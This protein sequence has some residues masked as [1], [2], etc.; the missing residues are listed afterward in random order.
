MSK[1]K[2]QGH[3]GSRKG[4]DGGRRQAPDPRRLEKTLN[5]IGKLLEEQHFES[6]D[7]ANAFLQQMLNSEQGLTA[8]EPQ[9]PL[10][11][12]QEYMY[13]AWRAE[14]TER[15]RLARRALRICKDCADAY[16][17]L[18]EETARSL[19]QA[20]DL[21]E[22]GVRAAERALGREMFRENAG[23]FWGILETRP[24]MRARAGLAITLW[25]LHE[26]QEAIEH[27]QDLLRLNPGDNQGLRYLLATC[28]LLE[29][30]HDELAQ[31]LRDYEG[32]GTAYWY[33]TKAL[34]S[35]R[36]HGDTVESDRLLWAAFKQNSL[37][38]DYLLGFELLPDQMPATIGFGDDSEA[39]D[40]AAA[41]GLAWEQT[42]GA[43]AWLEALWL[44]ELDLYD[45]PSLDFFDAAAEEM[46]S[47][48]IY[49][50]F[51]LQQWLADMTIPPSEHKTVQKALRAGV[52]AYAKEYMGRDYF[53]REPQSV[54][55][56]QLQDLFVFG[57]GAAQI[58]Q[59]DHVSRETKT[60]VAL[61]ALTAIQPA[62]TN[63]IPFGLLGLLG[64]LAQA[65]ALVPEAF[66]MSLIALEQHN[67][68]SFGS[69]EWMEGVTKEAMQSLAEWIV[70]TEALAEDEKLWAV[71]TL[72]VHTDYAS[73]L[74]KTLADRWFNTSHVSDDLKRD[75]CWGWIRGDSDVGTPPAMRQIMDAYLTGDREHMVQL[76][77]ENDFDPQEMPPLPEPTELP[78]GMESLLE[79]RRRFVFLPAYLKRLAIPGLVR[80][81]E[82]LEA[83]VDRFWDADSDYYVDA[84]NNGIAD[85]IG[86][87]SDRLSPQERRRLIERGINY[88]R[89]TTRKTFY[90]LSTEFYGDEYLQRALDDNAGSIRKWAAGKLKKGK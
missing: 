27:L 35:F 77:E 33:Y 32:E 4:H 15:V 90:A 3:H 8:R 53:K 10:E 61:Y 5:D 63:G 23:H 80:Y 41:N 39:I 26:R 70:T 82:R 17:L 74:G 51:E 47:E 59:S 87:Y 52:G 78:S 81:G 38:P 65:E 6:I 45:E 73:H 20:R 22:K 16:V 36:Q 12:A 88:R 48:E 64:Y 25:Q 60:K 55:D 50:P 83:V 58:M 49:F 66:I 56:E 19:Q 68:F 2:K 28:L 75:L 13:Q 46:L 89:A 31:L 11:K 40:Y 37:V 54:I 1:K 43:L 67:L 69:L 21:Y 86:E 84:L 14:G 85:A 76:I 24:Y 79:I 62:Y 72:S 34:L 18:A 42:P 9:T 71:W 29:T 7:E 44:E 57:H 30:R